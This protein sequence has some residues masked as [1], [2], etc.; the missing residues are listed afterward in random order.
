MENLTAHQPYRWEAYELLD[1][2]HGEKLERFGDIT[3]IRPE[4]QAFWGPHQPENEWLHRANARFRQDG[5]HGGTWEPLRKFPDRWWIT[6]RLGKGTLKMR[7]ATT[8]F[9]H[10]GL[11]PEQ[12]VNWDYSYAAL[13]RMKKPRVLNL[14]AYTGGA[15]LAAHMAGAQVTHVD[16][17]RQIL[18]WASEN[19]SGNQIDD[20]RWLKEDAFKFV[21]KE[22]RRERTYNGVILD[23]PA[24][25]HG[26]KGERWKLEDMLNELVGGVCKLLD[27]KQ[28]FLILNAY[29]LGLSPLVLES[30]L[31]SHLPK[32]QLKNLEVG[33]LYLQEAWGGRKLPAGVFARLQHL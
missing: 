33:E 3:L 8:G 30:L 12:A 32:W 2:G 7:L 18:N 16:S 1:S 31:K 5:P 6:Y 20:I 14:F 23:P 27:P 17:V 4:P 22:V 11:F 29:S 19:A 28:H 24:F 21:Q 26:P 9:K 15:S 13:V 25:G 10:V